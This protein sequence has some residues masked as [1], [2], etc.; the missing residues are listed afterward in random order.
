MSI[1]IF[2]LPK[3]LL[4]NGTNDWAINERKQYWLENIPEV[5]FG[6]YNLNSSYS[7]QFSDRL[8]PFIESM[9]GFKLAHAHAYELCYLKGGYLQYHKD[10]HPLACIYCVA[11]QG[12]KETVMVIGEERVIQKEGDII[13]FDGSD[14]L[15][16]RDRFE[17]HYSLYFLI[18]YGCKS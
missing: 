16:K 18:H 7:R 13:I 5:A 10:T 17:G 9:M 3:L 14:K 15:H 11:L 8:T 12:C 1:T 6:G 4:P 2:K